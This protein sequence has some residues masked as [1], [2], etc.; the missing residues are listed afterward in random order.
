MRLI[1]LSLLAL[2]ASV[3]AAGIAVVLNNSPDPIYVWSVG[4][5][6]GPRHDIKAGGIYWE[7]MHHDDK[8]GGIAIKMTKEADGLNSG[9]PQQ[10]WAYNLDGGTV[11]YDLSTVF[12]APFAGSRLDVT[13][14]NGGSIVWPNGIHPGGNQLTKAPS[15]GNIFFSINPA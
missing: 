12:G 7:E 2:I 10:V 5:T 6:V 9:A 11:W 14:D 8:S 1:I 13:G 15:E 4:G 3:R